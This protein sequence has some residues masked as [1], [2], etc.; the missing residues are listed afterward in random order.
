MKRIKGYFLLTYKDGETLYYPFDPLLRYFRTCQRNP[1][2][3]GDRPIQIDIYAT[4]FDEDTYK[5]AMYA[6]HPHYSDNFHY[7]GVVIPTIKYYK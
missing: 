4:H 3:R 7:H 6:I 1:D 5:W 2:R